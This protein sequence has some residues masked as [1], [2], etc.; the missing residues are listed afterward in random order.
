MNRRPLSFTSTPDRCSHLGIRPNHEIVWGDKIECTFLFTKMYHSAFAEFGGNGRIDLHELDSLFSKQLWLPFITFP[1]KNG[2]G[3]RI[4][5]DDLRFCRPPPLSAW[6]CPHS[7]FGFVNPKSQ[8]ANPKLKWQGRRDSNP[9]SPTWRAGG[10]N[11]FAYVLEYARRDLNSQ[12]AEFKSTASAKLGYAHKKFD[13]R[14]WIWTNNL[15]FLK[16]T[17]LARLGYASR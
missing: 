17:P 5:T 2:A 8:I 10:L 1:K 15:W 11:R 16:P 9:Q 3:N 14:G 6:L 13:T 4:W 12:S 7:D